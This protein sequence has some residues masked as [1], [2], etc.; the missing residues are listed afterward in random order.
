MPLLAVTDLRTH[1]HTR[2]GVY[3]AVDGV[4]FS[5]E[6]GET[7]G[8]VGESGCGKSVTCYSLMGLVPQP[9]GRIEGGS[10]V[11]DGKTDLLN[12]SARELNQIRGRRMAMIFQDPM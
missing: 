2:S 4:S 5:V 12:C 10:A 6:R 11:F 7:L 3:R 8:I 9:P 1:F